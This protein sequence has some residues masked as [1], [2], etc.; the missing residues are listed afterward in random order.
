M[1]NV[2]D[3]ETS[4]ISTVFSVDATIWP[5][6]LANQLSMSGERAI[7]RLRRA[8]GRL[9]RRL[10]VQPGGGGRSARSAIDPSTVASTGAAGTGDSNSYYPRL[11][12]DG[13]YVLFESTAPN[14]TGAPH[15]AFTYLVVRDLQ[16]QTTTVASRKP[17]GTN[18]Q[19][20]LG[21]DQAFSA[22]G[23]MVTFTADHN[24]MFGVMAG[25]QVYA[26]PRP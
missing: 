2:Y 17:D 5:E 13:Q 23:S 18:V 22:D 12:D 7:H 11:S 6:G 1:V 4:G 8:V 3:V 9:V 15:A 25:A 16:A 24:N 26:A 20:L 19:I 10:D 14:L 21:G